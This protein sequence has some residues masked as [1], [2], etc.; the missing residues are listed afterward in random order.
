M[1]IERTLS[2]IKPDAVSKG[3][4]E[5]ICSRIEQSGLSI[6]AKKQLNLSKRQ[7]HRF[8]I[9]HEGKSFFQP[10]IE[11]MT[12]GPIQ[13]QILQ[14]NNAI[15]KY[16][17]LMGDTNPKEAKLGTLRADFA[18]SIDSNAV[19]GS[20]S[21]SSARREIQFFFSKVDSHFTQ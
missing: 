12:S 18:E 8:Y 20:D 13:V 4:I 10:L 16:R 17:E 11:F 6:Q 2:I 1:T 5:E 7:A 21:V 14:G 19:H 9:E 15:T 3:Y